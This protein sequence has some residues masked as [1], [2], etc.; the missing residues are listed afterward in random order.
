M[1]HNLMISNQVIIHEILNALKDSGYE[2]FTARPWNYF[3]PETTLWWL[4]PSTE[5][6]SYKYGKL[7][8][9]RTKEGYRIGFHIEKGISELAGQM[10]TSKSAR[11][12][13]IK[14]EWAWH[15]FISDL[16]NGVFENRLKG[17]SESAKLPLRIS[18]QASNVTGEYDPYSEKIEGLETDHTMA[19]EYENGELKILQDEFKGEMRKYSNIGKLT[20]LI[21]VFQEKD[22][23][24]FWIDMFITAEV[25]IIN[26]T[27]INE[28][29]LTFVKFYKKIFGFLDR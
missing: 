1:E 21:S 14:P 25:E 6:P 7:V 13:C 15:N 2:G 16:S 17:I 19:F 12:L 4:V 18:L 5:W 23:D 11:K 29:A 22:M 24:W 27:H 8:L 20:E 3:K 28:L 9:Y 10:L 26:K